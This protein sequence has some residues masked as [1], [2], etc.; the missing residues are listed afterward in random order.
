[1][2]WLR[3]LF[4]R[5]V[6]HGVSDETMDRELGYHIAE[7]ARSYSA[8]G[9]TPDEAHRRALLEFGGREQ[10]KQ[11]I[12]EVHVSS[13]AESIA[14][15]AQAGWRFLSKSPTFSI[16]VILTLALAIG[17]NSAV[18]SAINA[19]V[20]RP[21][22]YPSGD[23]LAALYQHDAKGRDANQFVAPARLEDWNRMNTTFQAISGY[24]L[25]DLSETSGSLP[26]RVAEALV[27]PRFLP[28]MGVS[29]ALGRAF[30]REEEHWGG[31][32][33]VLI[34]DRFWQRR[35]HGDSSALGK[36]LHIGGTFYSIVGIMPASFQFPNRD[37]D[38]WAPS[39]PDAPYAVQR[40]ATWFTVVGRLKPGVTLG[41]GTADLV[42]VQ[43]QLG[44]QFPKPDGELI[45]QTEPLKETIVS[46]VRSSLWLLYGSV[47]L[48]L[49]IACLN[50]AAL[51]VA[52]TADREHEI[53]I[54][55]SLGASRKSIVAQLLSE[56]F[57]LAL[58]GSLA[59]LL[60]A[61]GASHGFHLLAKT[62]PRAEEIAIN[63]RVAAYSLTAAVATT[64]LCGL[65][66]ALRGT[67]R[68]LARALAAGSRTQV[69]TRSPLQWVL[70]MVQVSF[71]VTLLIGAGLL[72]R[73]LQAIAR[74][75]PGFDPSHVL[76]IQISGSW[77]ETTDM[78]GVTQRI[79]RTLDGLRSLPGVTDVATSATLPG[80]S[81]LYQIEFK[82]DG[83]LQPGHPILADSRYVSA[84][85]F[86]TMEIPLLVGEACRQASTTS[87]VVV[88]RAFADKYL[89]DTSPIGHLLSGVATT[90]FQPQATIRGI[91]GDAR[92]QGLNTQPVPTVYTCDSAPSP[93][94]NYL[95]RTQ[96]DPIAVTE[97]IR[98]RIH[99]LEPSRSVYGIS[100][101]QEHLDD[102]STENRLRTTLLSL[103]A[104]T[105]VALASI[106]L[107]GTLSYLGR[108]RRREVG[109]RLALGALRSQIVARFL[110]QGL[111]ATAIG[112][113]A[114]LALGLGLSRF[115]AG[116]L[117]GVTA[118]DPTTYASV[119][120]LILL[121]AALASL[122]PAMRAASVEPVKVLRE[123]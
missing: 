101:L 95:V 30:T 4:R 115:L 26:E 92:E 109:V 91:V 41:E 55:Y 77:G 63:W 105:A 66:P 37:V 1:M 86:G 116:M 74:V 60:V 10:V 56:V 58:L 73:S 38:L 28:V 106:G 43:S 49:L 39:P 24:Y 113:L 119:V 110:F 83:N 70:V 118:L 97:T 121:V 46:G 69:S 9:V 79:D 88:N 27:A 78:K 50:I 62:L 65:F 12:R 15:N 20:L 122:A 47:S 103:F 7:L 42:K 107:Y 112:C 3:R 99:E 98:R 76:T 34:S 19:V 100:S 40:S 17:A 84:G 85:Y 2:K 67:R 64:I 59:G 51:L 25:D 68:G 71:A 57:A 29:P 8:D 52:R 81:S 82:I 23:Q 32:D 18:F 80:V 44:K 22:P 117:Y 54:R 6:P 5:F 114:G 104:A 108:Q 94:P 61:A 102:A 14:F 75:Y 87:N 96:G 48:L 33:A 21:L 11:T 90:N 123:D 72:L 120:C 53:S 89:S 16:A 111:R 36:R 35:F 31:P 93:F 45:V 13:L